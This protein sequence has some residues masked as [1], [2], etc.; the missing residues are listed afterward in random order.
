VRASSGCDEAASGRRAE[1]SVDARESSAVSVE[2]GHH[3]VEGARDE[4]E[5]ETSPT[6]GGVVRAIVLM[7]V[8]LLGV[9][10]LGANCEP[11]PPACG[12]SRQDCKPLGMVTACINHCLTPVG[13]GMMCAIDSCDLF[14]GAG[15][16]NAGVCGETSACRRAGDPDPRVGICTPI[17]AFAPGCS[18]TSV[19]ARGN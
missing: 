9:G 17:D 18:T 19:G 8:I 1:N 3:F 10:A 13:N 14:V 15:I 5:N 16:P 7:G 12:R 4:R 2:Y 6:A 11:S